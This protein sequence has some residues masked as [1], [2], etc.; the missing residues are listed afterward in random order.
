MTVGFQ[1]ALLV[2]AV[3]LMG[4]VIGIGYKLGNKE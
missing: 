1:F 3:V 4:L 2:G